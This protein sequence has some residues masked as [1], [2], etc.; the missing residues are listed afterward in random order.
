MSTS[1]AISFVPE[2][3]ALA[4]SLA[5]QSS[6]PLLNTLATPP[7]FELQID[8]QGLLSLLDHENPKVKPL[9]V[10]F[11]TGKNRHRRLYG[12]GKGQDLA[13]A[14]GFNKHP[15][16]SIIDC[17]AGLGRDAF[18]IASLGGTVTLLERQ[19]TI[20]LLLESAIQQGQRSEDST[21][22]DIIQRMTLITSNSL[23]YLKAL[24]SEDYP[25][26]IYIDPMF[27]ERRKQAKVKKDMQFFHQIVGHDDDANALLNIALQRA[28]KR[29][30]VK[31][32]RTAP[33]LANLKPAF[34]LKGKSTRYDVYLPIG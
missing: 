23:D 14:I 22:V 16:L 20:A 32:P 3:K 6:L 5:K 13:K 8:P 17:T 26:I 30:V 25:D 34:T 1:I 29:I 24:R 19:A 9:T 11:T 33:S 2:Q 28:T 21:L 10:D 4:L 7:R 18:I 27:P 15:K 12:G 31:R